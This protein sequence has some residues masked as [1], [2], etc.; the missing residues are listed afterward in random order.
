MVAYQFY[1]DSL[2]GLKIDSGREVF[3]DL[4]DLERVSECEDSC[5]DQ[6]SLPVS[7]GDEE[8]RALFGYHGVLEKCPIV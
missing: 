1:G 5:E 4:S 7:V 6:C 2:L 3:I 8:V